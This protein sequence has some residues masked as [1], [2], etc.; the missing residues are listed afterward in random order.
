MRSEA[1]YQAGLITTLERLFPGCF[2]VRNDPALNQ[3]VPDLLILWGDR[4][5]MLEVKKSSREP[6]QPNQEFYIQRFNDMAFASAIY[7]ENEDE[8]LDDLQQAFR[9]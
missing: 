7:P 2:I 1:S 4:W 3:G 9:N 5:A 8:V 6:Y